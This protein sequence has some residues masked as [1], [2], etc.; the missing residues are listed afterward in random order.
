MEDKHNRYLDRVIDFLVRDTTIDYD[1]EEIKYPF[2]SFR[3]SLP[4]FS[5]THV[6]SPLPTFSTYV[7]DIYGL[8]EEELDYVWEKYRNIINEKI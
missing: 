2:P 8:T 6:S 5:P 4:I 1:R 3:G 7:R